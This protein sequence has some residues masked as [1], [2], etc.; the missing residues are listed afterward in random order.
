MRKSSSRFGGSLL[1]G[2]VAGVSALALPSA[3]HAD[4]NLFGY[5]T[6]TETLPKGAGEVYVFN[7]L[8]SD[9]G[10]GTYRAIDTEIEGEYGVTDR[11]PYRVRPAS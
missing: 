9:K 6:G 7:T 4:E 11:T 8:R 2:I 5:N 3:A 10:K 1:A